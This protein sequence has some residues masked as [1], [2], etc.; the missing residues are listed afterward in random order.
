MTHVIFLKYFYYD[1]NS[2]SLTSLC[3]TVGIEINNAHR[4]EDDAKRV[5]GFLLINIIKEKY[6]FTN[7]LVFQRIYECLKSFD[8]PNKEFFK[9]NFRF[10]N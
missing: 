6:F 4:A 2:F 7:I 9:K 5:P 10:F 1:P 8:V 3:K